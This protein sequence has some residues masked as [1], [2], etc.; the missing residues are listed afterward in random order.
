[1]FYPEQLSNMSQLRQLGAALSLRQLR[2]DPGSGH[3]EFVV[4]KMALR[5]VISEYFSFLCQFS[6]HLLLHTHNHLSSA[7]GIIGQIMSGIPSL[8]LN[9]PYS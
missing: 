4:N 6:L 3:L 8:I 1:M 5:Q 2:F 7:A 9:P